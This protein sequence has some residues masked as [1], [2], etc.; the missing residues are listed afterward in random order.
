MK[1]TIFTPVFEYAD[2]GAETLVYEGHLT[3]DQV[4]QVGKTIGHNH[5]M[6][7]HRHS[8]QVTNDLS[9]RYLLPDGN[10]E[11]LGYDVS[12]SETKS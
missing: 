1:I 10:P 9:I 12:Y 8:N 3:Q 6:T 5:E 11:N 2:Y 7:I 4:I